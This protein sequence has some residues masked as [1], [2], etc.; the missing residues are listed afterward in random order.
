MTIRSRLEQLERRAPKRDD[1]CLIVVRGG[2]PDRDPYDH[3]AILDQRFER[4]PNEDRVHFVSRMKDAAKT[5][6]SDWV[7]LGGLLH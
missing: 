7:V 4:T 3:A 2:L 5:A 1:V 6:G